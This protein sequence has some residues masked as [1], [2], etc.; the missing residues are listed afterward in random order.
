MIDFWSWWKI[1]ASLGEN[2]L[3]KLTEM[4]AV[5]GKISITSL[6]GCSLFMYA[7]RILYTCIKNR[8]K[9]LFFV[10]RNHTFTKFCMQTELQTQYVYMYVCVHTCI[11]PQPIN[12]MWL[13]KNTKF[14]LF[15]AISAVSDISKSKHFS[16][17]DL[18]HVWKH[19]FSVLYTSE[20]VHGS[21]PPAV[22]QPQ[23]L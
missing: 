13:I 10:S 15:S 18:V 4:M 22:I 17:D 23:Q 2:R 19:R 16:R 5:Q 21:K 14:T 7:L 3:H 6:P 1:N 8:K 20:L 12:K 11:I 9:M